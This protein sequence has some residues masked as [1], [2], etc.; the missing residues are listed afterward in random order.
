M[1]FFAI[2]SQSTSSSSFA[3]ITDSLDPA[4]LRRFD[5]QIHVGYPSAEG[6]RDIFLVH[7]RRIRCN[8]DEIDWDQLASDELTS[9]FLGADIQNVVN[10]A[11]LLAVREHSSAVNYNHFLRALQRYREMK[12]KIHSTSARG[13]AGNLFFNIPPI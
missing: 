12:G 4:I 9:G 8:L 5:R 7:A 6:R 3:M 2:D 11:A 13:S 10:D 1:D